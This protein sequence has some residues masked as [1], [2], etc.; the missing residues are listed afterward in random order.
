MYR[1]LLE[2]IAQ[3]KTKYGESLQPPCSAENLVEL[4]AKTQRK[5]GHALLEDYVAFLAITD[6]L[7]WD[8]L[9][10][11]ASQRRLISGYNDRWIDGFIERNLEE[12][13]F[14]DRMRDYVV[15]AE[16]GE[17]SFAL[18]IPKERYEVVSRVARYVDES[19]VSFDKLMERALKAHP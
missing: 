11:F 6:G 3:A 14:D 13:A 12:R 19:F 18:N 8:G 7:C 5:L 10:I 17:V 15:F 16:D 2:S 4:R 1:P 9:Y